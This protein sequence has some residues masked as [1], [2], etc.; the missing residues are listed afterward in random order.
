[1]CVCVCVCVS[2]RGT[3]WELDRII[4]TNDIPTY[5]RTSTWLHDPC[6]R[7]KRR[8]EDLFILEMVRDSRYA[9]ERTKSLRAG[10]IPHFSDYHLQLAITSG[11]LNIY[12]FKPER[13]TRSRT[14]ISCVEWS[15]N[16]FLDRRQPIRRI[17]ERVTTVYFLLFRTRI[18]GIELQRWYYYIM[19]TM[20]HRGRDAN[21]CFNR[22]RKPEHSRRYINYKYI[23]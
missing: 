2:V 19:H 9:P 21:T 14:H 6:L 17:D 4:W 5:I 16:F 3:S 20:I 10:L 23:N 7:M 15:I 1:M 8:G 18:A 22:D 13:T 12:Q 11:Y